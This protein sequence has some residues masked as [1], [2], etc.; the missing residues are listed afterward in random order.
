MED[1]RQGFIPPA[2]T[3]FPLR[4]AHDLIAPLQR[5]DGIDG[6]KVRCLTDGEIQR[7][8]VV[9]FVGFGDLVVDIDGGRTPVGQ[10]AC[11]LKR[12]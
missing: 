3:R 2:M 7:D 11:H 6:L 5:P 1:T 4:G 9:V 12:G 8:L 10:G